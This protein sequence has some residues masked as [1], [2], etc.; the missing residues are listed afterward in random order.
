[1]STMSLSQVN[2]TSNRAGVHDDI[3]SGMLKDPSYGGAL[4]MRDVENSSI[5]GNYFKANLAHGGGAIRALVR[6]TYVGSLNFLSAQ[7]KAC[8]ASYSVT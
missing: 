2:F 6:R 8:D 5:N 7:Y 3:T 4:Y 1:M